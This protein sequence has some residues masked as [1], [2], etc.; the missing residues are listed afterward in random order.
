MEFIE[1][2]TEQTTAMT[3]VFVALLA[4]GCVLYLRRAGLHERW[5]TNVWSWAFGLMALS[6]VVGAVAHGFKMSESVN[7]LLWQPI[8]LALGLA[9]SLFV[10]GVVYDLWGYPT[11]RQVLP[12]MLVIGVGFYIVTLIIPGSFLVF[13]VYE[14]LALFFAL[15]AYGWLTTQGRLKGAGLMATGIL[16]SI[17]AAGIQASKAVSVTLFWDFDH[18]GIFHL[19]QLV[20][21]LFLL[22]GLRSALLSSQVGGKKP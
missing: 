4:L 22:A 10:V 18:N 8:N 21:L 9:V 20:G 14:A 11:A 15:G 6:G 17:I 12:V 5:K 1:I 16:I 7:D 2:P 19:V 13:I 3:D